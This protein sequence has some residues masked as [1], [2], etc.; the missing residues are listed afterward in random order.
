M[1]VIKIELWPHGQEDKAKELAKAV[2]VNTTKNE[3]IKIGDY[4]AEFQ[5]T[6]VKGSRPG[7]VKKH[8]RLTEPV[9]TLL[10][11]CLEAAGY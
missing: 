3:D 7:E 8:A 4:F 6:G 10:R 1:L 2:I 11:K 5:I 9:W